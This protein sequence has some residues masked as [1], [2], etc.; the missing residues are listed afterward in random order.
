LTTSVITNIGLGSVVTI[1]GIANVND[2]WLC[3][4]THATSDT[5][6]IAASD[7]PAASSDQTAF[8]SAGTIVC[9]PAIG[10]TT[11]GIV[12]DGDLWISM[13]AC[14]DE[15]VATSAVKTFTISAPASGASSFWFVSCVFLYYVYACAHPLL[16]LVLLFKLLSGLQAQLFIRI[17]PSFFVCSCRLERLL[18]GHCNRVRPHIRQH[19][20][21]CPLAVLEDGYCLSQP[22]HHW[23]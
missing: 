3:W 8:G 14:S 15:N 10:G 2:D 23:C 16:F 20:R 13:I 22:R 21:P 9:S 11:Y 19:C 4:H 6:V 12:F 17:S 7:C 5:N 1:S 18:Y